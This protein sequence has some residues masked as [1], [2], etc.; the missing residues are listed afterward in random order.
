[1]DTTGSTDAEGNDAEGTDETPSGAGR[2]PWDCM[3]NWT[4]AEKEWWFMGPFPGGVPGLIRRIRRVLDVSQRGLAAL[5]GV[6]QSVVA[7][8]ETGRTSPRSSV[9]EQLLRKARLAVSLHEQGTGETVEP[10]RAD[11][12]RNRAGSRFP[13]H[14]DLKVKG[15]WIPR[16]LRTWTSIEAYTWQRRSR[17]A[18]DV[19][20]GYSLGRR[21]HVERLLLGTPVDHP[22]RH[23]L[24]VEM[25]ARDEERDLRRQQFR[26]RGPAQAS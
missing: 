24:V 19:A 4:E 18:G 3:A 9:L 21:K 11:G 16:R 10:M 7:R 1:M 25:R 2:A 5:L 13:A 23:Q 14:A 6:S 20:I 12:A 8:W 22:A 26:A 17:E 15:W